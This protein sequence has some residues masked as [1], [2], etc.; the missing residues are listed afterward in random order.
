MLQKEIFCII[1]LITQEYPE[2]Q[3]LDRRQGQMTEVGQSRPAM[4]PVWDTP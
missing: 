2:K 4:S 1:E 3:K